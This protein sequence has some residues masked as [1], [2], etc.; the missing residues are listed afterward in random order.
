MTRFKGHTTEHA[1]AQQAERQRRY[2]ANM[3]ETARE[4]ENSKD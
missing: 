4:R 2:R 3:M 1:R